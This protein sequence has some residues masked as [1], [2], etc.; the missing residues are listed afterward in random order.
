[1]F[2]LLTTKE[3]QHDIAAKVKALRLSLNKTQHNFAKSI[4]M[5]KSTYIRFE[6]DGEGSFESFIQILKGLGRISELENIL[7]S[8]A[9]SPLDAVKN[10][11]KNTPRQRATN[12]PHTTVKTYKINEDDNKSFMQMIKEVKD[13][14]SRS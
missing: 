1:M 6:N 12:H 8:E 5:S 3:I 14:S 13:E 4:G 10:E 11:K 2:E 7:K 9:Y